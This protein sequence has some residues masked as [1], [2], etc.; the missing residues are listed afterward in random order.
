[1]INQ[2]LANFTRSPKT[3]AG[4]MVAALLIALPQLGNLVGAAT[5]QLNKDGTPALDGQGM[6]VYNEPEPVDWNVLGL[7]IAVFWLGG[8]SRDGD[9]SSEEVKRPKDDPS[10][11]GR[12]PGSIPKPIE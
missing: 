1:M 10:P 8:Q 2:W 5:P 4:G 6:I 9:R 3:S 7:A 11:T 12:P